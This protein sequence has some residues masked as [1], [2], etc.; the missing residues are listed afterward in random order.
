[1]LKN[2]I[3]NL[4]RIIL[5]VGALAITAMVLF[6][7]WRYTIVRPR[8]DNIEVPG[9]YGLIFSPPAPTQSRCPDC[10][11]EARTV[12]PSSEPPKDELDK[13]LATVPDAKTS[14]RQRDVSIRMDTQRL[15]VQI[16]AAG[17]VCGLLALATRKRMA[18]HT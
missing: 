12:T 5:I 14:P 2:L 17:L 13:L 8:R 18:Q 3:N 15:T 1:M 6:P 16:L 4:S 10:W 11:Y 7:P 9:G